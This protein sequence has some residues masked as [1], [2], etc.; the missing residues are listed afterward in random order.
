MDKID[1]N[2]DVP[3]DWVTTPIAFRREDRMYWKHTNESTSIA[4][5]VDAERIL[6]ENF[7]RTI[8]NTDIFLYM[9]LVYQLCVNIDYITD[10][11]SDMGLAVD[12][13]D[14]L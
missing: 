10:P 5:Y 6:R 13:A 14:D 1:L 11:F 3:A 2:L 7:D 9:W 8:S 12:S 4:S